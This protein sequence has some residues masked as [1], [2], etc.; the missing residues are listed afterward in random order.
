MLA[1]EQWAVER[2][3]QLPTDHKHTLGP[4]EKPLV[5]PET[6]RMYACRENS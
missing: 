3:M 6:E 5:F 1:A 2:D 4:G